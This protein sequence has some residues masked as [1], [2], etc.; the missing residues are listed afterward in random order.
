MKTL[1]KKIIPSALISKVWPFYAKLKQTARR[2]RQKKATHPYVSK[3]PVLYFD[4]STYAASDKHTGI[5]RVVEQFMNYLPDMVANQFDFVCVSGAG[6]YHIIDADTF[7]PNTT[8]YPNPKEG[9]IFLSIDLNHESH[10][11]EVRTLRKWKN[12]GCYMATCIYDLVAIMYPEFVGSKE[13]VN[14]LTKWLALVPKQFD[15]AICISEAVKNEYLDWMNTMGLKDTGIAVE[16][17][18]LGADFVERASR[19]LSVSSSIQ[20]LPERLRNHN[21]IIYLMVSTVE[22]R[23]G[24]VDAVKAF[25]MARKQR[26]DITLVIVGRRGWKYDDIAVSITGSIY[27]NESL[28]WM[29]DCDDSTLEV[30]YELSD[31]YVTASYYE[32]FGLGIIEAAHKGLPVI[33]RDIPVHREV[34]YG[35]ACYFNS[36][37]NLAELMVEA[38]FLDSSGINC[39]TWKKSVEMAWITIMENYNR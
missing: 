18:H 28:F 26:D 19:D 3:R 13:M 4:I 21:G 24:Y 39:L 9:D 6:G 36:V 29:D 17:Y 31:A 30:L 35:H 37:E 27:Y 14:R 2:M 16:Y 20:G 23:K 11:I 5:Q 7:A 34:S 8:Y 33:A 10:L 12:A 25:E 22:P 32:G 15:T 1:L 38:D